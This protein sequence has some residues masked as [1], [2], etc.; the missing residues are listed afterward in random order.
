M[1][2]ALLQELADDFVEHDYDLRRLERQILRSSAWQASSTPNDTN[3]T[4][5]RDFARAYARMPP[6]H[7][8]ADMVGTAVTAVT[9]TTGRTRPRPTPCQ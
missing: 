6:P 2:E 8:V 9:A 4:D 7:V 1:Y 5:R 3:R